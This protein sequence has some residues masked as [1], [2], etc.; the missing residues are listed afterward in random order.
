MHYARCDSILMPLRKKHVRRVVAA[1]LVAGVLGPIIILA[2]YGLAVRGSAYGRAVAAELESHL[3][4]KADVTNARPT[5][6][7]TAAADALELTWATE[8]GTLALRLDDLS[9]ES[10]VYGW[11]VRAARGRL[12]LAGAGPAETLA[13]L[14]QRLVQPG[15]STRLMSLA[16]ERLELVFDAGGR[17]LR[18][19]VRAAVLSNMTEYAVSLFAPDAKGPP[20]ERAETLPL[21]SVRFSPTSERGIFEGLKADVKCLA[22]G[23]RRPGDATDVHATMDLAADWGRTDGRA[24]APRV[25]LMLRG[26]ALAPWTRATP[27][28]PVVGTGDF[29]I[30]YTQPAQGAPEVDIFLD[31]GDG[32]MSAATLVW[33]ADLPAGLRSAPLAGAGMIDFDRIALRCR[34]SGGRGEFETSGAPLVSARFLG[35]PVPLV[36]SS[37]KPF[38]TRDVWPAVRDALGLGAKGK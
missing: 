12:V 14:N 23:G 1:L 4:C 16:V 15:G 11:Y 36:W 24:T 9:A 33:L 32:R 28:G 31:S 6:P 5:G 26:L 7:S 35:V 8:H 20:G 27:G 21:A 30:G 10:N 22:L 2:V 29:A 34:A 37:G 13:A 18:T 25:R 17:R 38:E 3:R 19:E